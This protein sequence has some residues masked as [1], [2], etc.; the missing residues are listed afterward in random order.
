MTNDNHLRHLLRSVALSGVLLL[1]A[2]PAALAEPADLSLNPTTAD[3][4]A[5][6]ASL[7]RDIHP[8]QAATEDEIP[9]CYAQCTADLRATLWNLNNVG[10]R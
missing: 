4:A 8:P 7:N 2:V 10:A 1:T 9:G 6:V 5:Y 3:Y